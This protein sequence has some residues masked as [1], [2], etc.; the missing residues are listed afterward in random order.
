MKGSRNV[1]IGLVV[2]VMAVLLAACRFSNTTAITITDGVAATPYPSTIH[3]DFIGDISGGCVG[4]LNVILHG[5]THSNPDDIDILLAGPNGRTVVLMSDVGGASAVNGVDLTFDDEA[6][7]SLP[8]A[9]QIVTGAYR[10]TDFD[11]L[12]AFPAGA[13]ALR[14]APACPSSTGDRSPSW[15]GTSTWSTTPPTRSP[16]PSPAGGA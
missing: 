10:P 15:T 9:A 4:D 1:R 7:G 14:M 12:D 5:V 13:P 3:P 6:A 16:A 8:D 2:A 11:S